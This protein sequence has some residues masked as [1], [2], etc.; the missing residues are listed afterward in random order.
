MTVTPGHGKSLGGG[1]DPRLFLGG[2]LAI[3]D[4]DGKHKSDGPITTRHPCI[5]AQHPK[6][7]LLGLS[8]LPTFWG[9]N[10]DVRERDSHLHATSRQVGVCGP[11][12]W[13]RP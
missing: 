7:R 1:R 12:E 10:D 9:Q 13:S 5:L 11:A 4:V 3:P 2:L 6:P 8:V